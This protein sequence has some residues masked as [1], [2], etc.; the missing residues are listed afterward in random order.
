VKSVDVVIAGGGPFG[1]MAAIELGRRGVS[2][3]LFD[4]KAETAFNPQANATQARTMEYF[5]RLGFADEI[6]A[7]GLPRDFPTD[8]SYFTRYSGYELGRFRLPPS[9]DAANMVSN[10]DGPWSA[11]EAPHRI[12]QK[13]VE[14]V[15]R[16]QAEALPSVTVRF[17]SLLRD[18]QE[19]ADGVTC[20]VSNVDGTAPQ[21]LTA[22]ILIG[23]DG[24]RSFIRKKQGYA[25]AGDYGTRRHF[26]GGRMYAVYLR[27][28]EFY[29]RTG[30]E[31]A[32]MHWTFNTE[33]RAFMA[34][35]DGKGDFAFHT[36]LRE[37][38]DET[39]ITDED[40]KGFFRLS[41]GMDI[42]CEVLDHM[43]WIAGHALVANQFG[44]G[45]VWIGGDAAHLFT[46]TGGLG[47]NTAVEDAVNLSWKIAAWL[48]GQGGDALLR[49][50][51]FERQKSAQ[52][53]TAYARHFADS[54][55]NYVPPEGIED[56][57]EAG[58]ALRA[59]A[60]AYLTD[61]A[62]REF[63]IPGVTFGTR[64]DGSPVL[65]VPDGP[66]PA[67][68]A[69]HYEPSG[70]PGGRPPHWWFDDGTSLFDRFGLGWTLLRLGD[71]APAGDTLI[72]QAM[73][74]GLDLT[75]LTLTEPRLRALYGAPLVLIR[76]DQII[77]WR[78]H[79][80][81]NAAAVWDLLLGRG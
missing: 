50:Y 55:G 78:G 77:G 37:D 23:A 21:N 31:P 46:P 81:I 33:R 80:E 45:R 8:I 79:G 72:T 32:W 41:C 6:R 54:I 69:N 48:N 64:Y 25:L 12:S 22:R 10:N 29:A 65:P 40:A 39:A 66:L 60:G 5:R 74:R 68:Q 42:D 76:P 35:V 62:R 2:V 4:A 59:A 34:A 52:R 58:D 73:D 9:R 43:G 57:G 56:P 61:H 27:C 47:Y 18:Y 53:N 67:D 26:M 51:D 71:D 63:N 38:E 49:S 14:P 11:A 36:Q 15:L 24:S 20:Q 3:A 70:L 28:P 44:A 17:S 16:R 13:Y 1:L 7:E 30:V 75:V 19:T